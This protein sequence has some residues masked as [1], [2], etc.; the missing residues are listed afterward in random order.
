MGIIVS[1]FGGS[2]MASASMLRRVRALVDG[3]P[4]RRILVVSAPG[5]CAGHSEKVT[6]LLARSA[7]LY[8]GGGDYQGALSSVVSR[9]KAIAEGL[10]TPFDAKESRTVL[11][12]ALE[13]S[14]AALLSRG[15]TLC[16]RL[17]ADWMALPFL[18]ASDVI[19]FDSANRLNGAETLRRICDAF[20]RL[21]RFVLP[22]FYGADA[23]GRI[24]TFPRNGSDIT[25]ALAAAAVS[26]SLYEN[27]T[28]VPGVMTADPFIVP[29]ARVIPRI[30][31]RQ[32]RMLTRAGAQVLHPGC[33]D[34]VCMAGIPTR[35]CGTD[36]PNQFGTLITDGY[37]HTAPCIA[38]NAMPDGQGLCAVTAFALSPRRLKAA[39]HLLDPVG[40]RHSDACDRFWV[41][42]DRRAEAARALHGLIFDR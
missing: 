32:M 42:W 28:D 26:A 13:S 40:V 8:R 22:G 19:C 34:P 17:L 38:V 14:E 21:G 15:E 4:D 2:S 37:D 1:K 36:R 6:D 16:A 25:G 27:W 5:R 33:L 41:P 39:V 11:Q 24:V 23:K 9:F 20:D 31:Y 7:R 35:L 18:D 10:G 29:E 30:S 12:N 3:H